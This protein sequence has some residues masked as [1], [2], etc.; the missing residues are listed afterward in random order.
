M[1]Q[2]DLLNLP[3]ELLIKSVP[4]LLQHHNAGV[5]KSAA[6]VMGKLCGLEG[7]I[8]VKKQLMPLLQD[9][10]PGVREE[11]PEGITRDLLKPHRIDRLLV[12]LLPLAG[13]GRASLW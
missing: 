12:P 2:N 8:V 13:S 6:S 9:I 4:L 7:D 5:R 1:D 10:D 3:H 11:V